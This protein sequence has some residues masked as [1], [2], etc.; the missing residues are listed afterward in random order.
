MSTPTDNSRTRLRDGTSQTARR[1]KALQPDYVQI[2]ERSLEDFLAFA[3][4]YAKELNFYDENNELQGDWTG[5]IHPEMDLTQAAAYAD[6]PQAMAADKARTFARPHFALFLS[7]LKLLGHAQQHMNDFTRRHLEFY[8]EKILGMTKKAAVADHVSVLLRPS[9]KV[10]ETEVPAGHLLAAGRDSF[11]RDRF[12]RTDRRIV[13]NHADIGRLSAVYANRQMTGIREARELH[14]GTREE[15]VLNMLAVALGEPLPGD[16]LP[17][18]DAGRVVDY[19]ALLKLESLVNFTRDGLFLELFELRDLMRFKQQR[20]QADD[21]WA[22]INT[23]LEAIGKV[24]TGD[25]GFRLDPEDPRDFDANLVKALGGAPSFAGLPQVEN[26]DD[27]YQQRTLEEVKQYVSNPAGLP[28][29]LRLLE[30]I[31][32]RFDDFVSMMQ[33]KTAIDNEWNEINR[34]LEKA[35]RLKRKDPDYQ[36]VPGDDTDFDPTDFATNFEAALGAVDFS[37]HGVDNIDDYFAALLHLEAYFLMSAENFAYLMNLA[38]RREDEIREGEWKKVY[39][40]LATAYR[41]KVYRKRR[42][43]LKEVREE[44]SDMLVGYNAMLTFALGEE[45]EDSDSTLKHLQEY[46]QSPVSYDK[47][48]SVEN[49]IKIGDTNTIDWSDVYR[50]VELAQRR[51]EKLPEPVAQV[52]EWKNLHAYNDVTT[53]QIVGDKANPRWKT[54]GS[55]VAQADQHNPPEEAFGWA[56][57]SPLLLLSGGAR[58][59]VLTCGFR[60]AGYDAEKIKRLF[61]KGPVSN[62]EDTGPFRIRMTTQDGWV[63]PDTVEVKFDRY[64]TLSGLTGEVDRSLDGLQFVLKFSEQAD[65]ITAPG[66][67]ARIDSKWPILTL[68][69]RQ[70][71]DEASKQY[72][73]DYVPFEPLELATVHL[74]V[75]VGSGDV[76]N[77]SGLGELYIQNDQTLLDSSKPFHPFGTNPAVGSRFYIGHPEL[78]HKRL[79][80]LGFGIEWMGGPTDLEGHYANYPDNQFTWTFKTQISLIDK[81]VAYTVADASLFNG[82]DASVAHTIHIGDVPASL[83]KTNASYVYTR[84]LEAPGVD[85]LLNWNRYLQWE[86]TPLD[87]QHQTYPAVAA[88][89]SVEMAAAIANKDTNGKVVADDYKVNPPYTPKIKQLDLHY[90]ASL[91]IRLSAYEPWQSS[92]QIFHV[93]PFGFNEVQIQVNHDSCRFLPEYTDEGELY[94]GIT[95]ANPPQHL[96]VLFQM[97]EGS[98]NPDLEP[99]PVEWSYLSGDQW[100]SLADGGIHL[101]T[102]RGLIN[103]GIIEFE[104]RP[105]QPSTRM[106]KGFYWLRASIARNSNSVCDTVAVHTQAVPATLTD[107]RYAPDHYTTPLPEKQITRLSPPVPGIAEVL[108]PYTSFGGK[109]EE[110]ESIFYTRVSERLRHKQRALTIWDYERLVLEQFPQIYKAKCLPA[111]AASSPDDAGKLSLVVI[112]DVRGR[113]PFDPFEPKAPADLIASI[114]EFLADKIP[115][116]ARVEVRNAHYVP[117]KVRVGVR[118]KA[119]YDIGFYKERSIDELNQFLSPWA[120]DEGADIVIGGCIYANSIINF[121]DQREYVDYV[122]AIRLFSSEDGH[123]FR[124]AHPGD[125]QGYSVT[126]QTPDGVLV[127]ARRHEIDIIEEAG[128]EEEQFIGINYMKIELDFVVG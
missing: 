8:Y 80:S 114:R 52:V 21:Q 117:V 118:F 99:V 15:A 16:P 85:K 79:D 1:Q 90:S 109:P 69:L 84:S 7:F 28:D 27:L 6:D 92:D 29:S 74:Q 71:W 53:E 47:L 123:N 50:I 32:L 5:L 116:S 31:F 44:E 3:R 110:Q 24:R 108:Q 119:G 60:S 35:G 122:A 83:K 121:L 64:S 65:P 17:D 95:N 48:V 62:A 46:V 91:E 87:F 100:L 13:V 70:H 54:F 20:D 89:K 72:V 58:Q 40:F 55:R 104:L 26:I 41:N 57:A 14:K 23:E 18:Y 94:I 11:G 111:N 49:S 73:T 39:E 127:A 78:V 33:E 37:S 59:V 105:A 68:M 22:Q 101:D 2:D 12:Y 36:L 30:P 120:Y 34:I 82:N 126:T 77:P 25:P 61:P 45:V 76:A 102:T 43:K 103:T 97:A 98:A 107:N 93:H 4:E 9:P 56:I 106:P 81:R 115:P 51:R 66:E 112:P 42:A 124:L 10:A 128:Y 67:N 96:C 113:L 63:S 125:Q 88:Q 38:A 86:L 75:K 19:D